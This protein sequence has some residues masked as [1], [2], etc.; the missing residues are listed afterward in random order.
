MV[1]DASIDPLS[2]ASIVYVAPRSGTSGVSDYADDILGI[3]RSRFGSVVEVRCDGAGAASVADV[4]A[5]LRAVREALASTEG[6]VVLHTEASGGALLPFWALTL[7]AARKDPRVALSATLHDAPLA[8]AQP[9]RTRGVSKSR[10]LTHALHFPVLPLLHKYERSTL[11]PVKISALTQSGA[12]AIERELRHDPVTVSFLPPPVKGDIAPAAERPV[13]IGLFG[14]VY[15]GKGFDSLAQLRELIDPAIE[16][17]VAGRGTELLE[18]IPGVTIIGPVE[19]DQEDAFFSSVRVIVMPYA[20]RNSYG[21][22]TH[23]ASSVLA[24]AIAYGTPAIAL[25]YP[26]LGHEAIAVDGGLPELA[27]V[28]NSVVPDDT[29][30]AEAAAHSLQL[31]NQQTVQAAFNRLAQGWREAL[32]AAE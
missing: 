25:R 1:S 21:P 27:A 7:K 19:G 10:L 31:R 30:V 29:A 4:R 12:E 9:F 32:H 23:V 26:G 5:G 13:A 15:R 28:V 3:A 17:R 8:V 6:P 14:Y 2:Q 16:I 22:T 24:R 18:P 11:A 20:K